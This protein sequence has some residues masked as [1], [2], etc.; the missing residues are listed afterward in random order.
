M[1]GLRTAPCV[2]FSLLC[3][4]LLFIGN[5][6]I[7][8]KVEYSL[9]IIT[10]FENAKS[11][12]YAESEI[13]DFSLEDVGSWTSNE[14]RLL[15]E[16]NFSTEGASL[17]FEFSSLYLPSSASLSF[18][19]DM[20]RELL[21][22][23]H[24]RTS[25]NSPIW[26]PIF[27]HQKVQVKLELDAEE[28][29]ALNFKLRSINHG[30]VADAN[31]SSA[32]RS[33][34]I[35]V[36]CGAE[37]DL[38]IIDNYRDIIQSVG[39]ISINGTEICTGVLVNNTAND[40]TPYFLTA[41]HCGIDASNVK[42]VYVYWNHAN[43]FCRADPAANAVDGDGLFETYNAGATIVAEYREADMMLLKLDEEVNAEANAFFAGWDS[44][45][46]KPEHTITIHHAYSEEK[47]ISFD[48][49]APF[50]TRHFGEEED[51]FENHFKVL[52][53]DVS[54]T[55]EGSSGAPLFDQNKRV[56]G[57]L[58]GGQAD[59]GNKMPDWYGRVFNSWLGDDLPE[60]QLKYWLDPNDSGQIAIDGIWANPSLVLQLSIE[61]TEELKC[62]EDDNAIIQIKVQNGE[63]P[64]EYS[65]DGGE[66]FVE[67]SIFTNLSAGEYG[68]LV[69][70]AL[71]NL[72]E[73]IAFQIIEPELLTVDRNL[74]YDQLKIK[75]DGGVPPYQYSLNNSGFQEV[76]C[77]NDLSSG[78]YVLTIKDANECISSVEFT[79]D[80]SLFLAEAQ[81]IN[82]LDCLESDNGLIEVNVYSGG[83][84][85]FSYGLDSMS[86]QKE[87][88]FE[89]LSPGEYQ[90]WVQD[91]LGNLTRTDSIVL[92]ANPDPLIASIDLFE[93]FLV[94]NAVGGSGTYSYSL[95][96]ENFQKE[97]VFEGLPTGIYTVFVR[98]SNGCI[99]ILESIIITS[100]D[101]PKQK[102]FMMYPNPA[103]HHVYIEVRKAGKLELI[104]AQGKSLLIRHIEQKSVQKINVSAYSAGIYFYRYQYERDTEVIRGSFLINK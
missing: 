16:T 85:P 12:P 72:N 47:R 98:D 53:Y 71:G 88:L 26:T 29:D 9:P 86:F 63:A 57:Q 76:P 19:N 37:D 52:A 13:V 81:I 11:Y 84:A 67:E 3:F 39:L 103:Q 30:L 102:S 104:N 100:L 1:K 69:R 94:I 41:R 66:N 58:H 8:T 79:L 62:A 6:L 50:I 90:F 99:Y 97:N 44:G 89:N 18:Y 77:F 51:L 20:G 7:K 33:C 4:V 73:P 54:S 14:G 43:S 96:G 2:A 101:H 38:A 93:D 61:Q 46:Q 31:R 35:D 36:V 60:R 17:N 28:F 74:F 82:D 64:Y 22:L 65:I 25:Q 55:A 27:P 78:D 80:I 24:L 83:L 21:K 48:N 42:S 87:N 92:G 23:D 15:W 56:V 49:D 34:L 10:H 32:D 45:E 75:G 95:D 68:V 40:R 91:A 5:R 59:C 70:D